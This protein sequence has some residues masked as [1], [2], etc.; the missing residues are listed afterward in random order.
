MKP[1][2]PATVRKKTGK[3]KVME[4]AMTSCKILSFKNQYVNMYFSHKASIQ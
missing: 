1:N 3:G 4:E 2:I